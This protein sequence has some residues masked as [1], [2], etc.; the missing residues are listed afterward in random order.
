MSSPLSEKT[1]GFFTSCHTAQSQRHW[2]GAPLDLVLDVPRGE[3]ALGAE[4]TDSGGRR[5]AV[6]S[7]VPVPNAAGGKL[8][9]R[10]TGLNLPALGY[11]AI[12]YRLTGEPPTVQPI[13]GNTL[14]NE[15]YRV[16]LDAHGV[17]G[18][19]DKETNTTI[20]RQNAGGLQYEDD[21]GSPWETLARPIFSCAVAPSSSPSRTLSGNADVKTAVFAGAYNNPRVQQEFHIGRIVWRQEVTL[22]AGVKRIHFKT[23]VDW[24]THNGRLM[25]VFPL[26]FRTLNDE[27]SYEIPFGVL[28]RPRYEGRFGVHTQPNGDWPALNFVACRNAEKDLWVTVANRGTPC[29][30]LVDGVL[31]MTVLRSPCVSL[32]ACDIAGAREAGTH[33]FETIVSSGKGELQAVNPVRLGREFN[34]PFIAVTTGETNTPSL[35]PTHSFIEHENPAIAISAVKRAEDGNDL[36]VRLYEP[37]GLAARDQLKGISADRIR[38]A[39]LLEKAT[40]ADSDLHFRPYEIKTIRIS[41]Q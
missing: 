35:P 20:L 24:D 11:G 12:H 5:V 6:T 41:N 14:E 17:A 34:A 31:R 19:L 15:F 33:V 16:D 18:I 36:V 21:N 3:T 4:V 7:V 26:A 40:D 22:Y 23:T 25:L 30:R 37:Y 1:Y 10:L 8:T 13:A 2:E 32:G 29:H 39:D 38:A 27:A 9:V 28:N